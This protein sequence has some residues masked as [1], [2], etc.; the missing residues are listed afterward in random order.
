MSTMA[1]PDEGGIRIRGLS[2]LSAETIAGHFAHV[3]LPR[4]KQ[5]P[6]SPKTYATA[7]SSRRQRVEQRLRLF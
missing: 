7:Q 4:F 3:T 6:E 1:H 5:C 2:N